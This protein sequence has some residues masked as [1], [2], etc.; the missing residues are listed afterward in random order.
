MDQSARRSGNRPYHPDRIGPVGG[1]EESRHP[2]GFPHLSVVGPVRRVLS[3]HRTDSNAELDPRTHRCSYPEERTRLGLH[4]VWGLFPLDD[5]V[6]LSRA[7]GSQSAPPPSGLR[8]DSHHD[9]MATQPMPVDDVYNWAC[10]V[11]GSDVASKPPFAE[12]GPCALVCYRGAWHSRNRPLFR[13]WRR[14]DRGLG[15]GPD[16]SRTEGDLEFGLGTA[17]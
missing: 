11:R 7:G 4:D 6:R 3:R 15:K 5:G 12:T 8:N 2:T 1:P 9:H 16:N 14:Y 10:L 17:Y 13:S